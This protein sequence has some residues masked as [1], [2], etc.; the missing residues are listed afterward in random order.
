MLLA[1]L[2]TMYAS[3]KTT[4]SALGPALDAAFHVMQHVGGKMVVLQTVLPT[5]GA[6]KLRPREAPKLLGSDKEHTL[7]A[8]ETTDD[9]QL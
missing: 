6:G 8:P 7:L 1:S 4:E 5:V 3:N 2:P 9:G